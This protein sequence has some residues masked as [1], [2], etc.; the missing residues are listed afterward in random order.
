VR[1]TMLH[2]IDDLSP[3]VRAV[4]RSKCAIKGWDMA[5]IKGQS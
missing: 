1:D 5:Q 2:K 4:I 3:S